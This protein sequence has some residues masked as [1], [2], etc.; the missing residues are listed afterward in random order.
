MANTIVITG[1]NGSLAMPTIEYLLQHSPASTLVLTVRDAS[2]RDANTRTLRNIIAKH[3]KAHT[4][5]RELDLAHLAAVHDFSRS[6]AAEIARGTL[7]HLSAIVSTAFYWNL[8][9]PVQLSDDGYEKTIQVNY[10]SHFALILRLISS[11]QS[12]GGRIILFTSDGHEPGKNALEKIPPAVS[13]DLTQLQLLVKPGEDATNDA[14]GHGMYRYANSKLAL[15]MFTHALNRRLQQNTG[16]KNITAIV[17]NP[18]NLAD[19]RA[20]L[21]N[22][23]YKLVFLRNFVLRPFLPLLR[24]SKSIPLYLRNIPGN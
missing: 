10:L 14:L 23:P 1:A 24:M 16:L 5:I 21:V 20:L 15:V 13:S 17:M 3:P 18:G 11:F 22:T 6:I 19:S 8:V 12:E 7:P 4:S 2:N 9:D